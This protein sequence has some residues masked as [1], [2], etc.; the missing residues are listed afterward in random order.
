MTATSNK[1]VAV[2]LL[3]ATPLAATASTGVAQAASAPSTA[4]TQV[5]AAKVAAA[6]A[7]ARTSS[8]VVTL[9]KARWVRLSTMAQSSSRTRVAVSSSAKIRAPKRTVKVQLQV[10]QLEGSKVVS[11]RTSSG[12]ANTRSWR[13]LKAALTTVP[14][15][16]AGSL[17]LWARSTGPRAARITSASLTRPPPSPSS[18]A[19]PPRRRRGRPTWST[20]STR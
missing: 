10:R 16:K 9:R 2:A 6:P 15:T 3:L 14:S 12:T 18:P 8:R 7:V 5:V 20:T 4:R 17:E 1:R 19:R 13:S 11:S